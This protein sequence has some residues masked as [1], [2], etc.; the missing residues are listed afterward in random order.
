MIDIITSATLSGIIYDMLKT[1][2]KLSMENLKEHLRGWIISDGEVQKLKNELLHLN[3]NDGMSEK[4]I[5][6]TLESS[7]KIKEI[8]SGMQ[9]HNQTTVSQFHEGCGDN[10]ITINNN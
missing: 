7:D 3:L 6:S 2:T 1:S 5:Q 4:A 8:L 9:P 10:N